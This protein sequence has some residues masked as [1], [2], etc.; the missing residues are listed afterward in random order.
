[1]QLPVSQFLRI[2]TLWQKSCNHQHP[3]LPNKA[4]TK[5]HWYQFWKNSLMPHPHVH[6]LIHP[7]LF[8]GKGSFAS[9]TRLELNFLK[10][11]ATVQR[12]KAVA[13]PCVI[14]SRDLNDKYDH[15]LSFP[16]FL[17]SDQFLGMV[18]WFAQY[19][20]MLRF[21][22]FYWWVMV[23]LYHINAIFRQT[24][25][26]FIRENVSMFCISHFYFVW[27][28]FGNLKYRRNVVW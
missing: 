10:K 26:H 28:A 7:C 18:T 2:L 21:C 24:R 16:A 15:M 1:M 25:L 12:W 20:R 23:L 11:T 13:R 5:L 6:R 9:S 4:L 14:A 19:I 3:H 27:W 8:P 22:F 17:L